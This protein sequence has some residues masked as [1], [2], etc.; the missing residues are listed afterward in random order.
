MKVIFHILFLTVAITTF[1]QNTSYYKK[2]IDTLCSKEMFGRGYLKNGHKIAAN[3]IQNELERY[4]FNVIQQNFPI[5]VNTFPKVSNIFINDSIKLEVG[6]DFIPSPVCG[7]I[8][9]EFEIFQIDS[10]FIYSHKEQQSFIHKDLS[11]TVLV[12]NQKITKQINS[13]SPEVKRT[14]G[15][16]AAIITLQDSPLLGSFHTEASHIGMIDILDTS[17]PPNAAKIKLTIRNEIKKTYSQNV[18]ASPN[19]LRKK[20]PT[21]LITGHY[22]HLGGYGDSCF[23]SGANDNAS[24]IAMML[25]MARHFKENLID[26]NLIFMACGGE[27]VGLIGSYY[28]TEHPTYPLKRLDL[29]INLDLMGAGSK[30]IM[31]ENGNELPDVYKSFDTENKEYKLVTEIKKRGN[32]PNSDHYPFTQKDVKAIFIYSLGEVGGYH[33]ILDSKDKLEYRSYERLFRLLVGT[34][35]HRLTK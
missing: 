25:D 2:Q 21:I 9:G 1:S 3:Y 18:I 34:I 30:G 6:K 26:A 27:E 13:L 11:R 10:S 4:D 19:K 7:S 5:T 29:V 23:V 32:S 17:F 14:F 35:E 31:I 16:S 15:L 20:I 28:Y 12:Y 24:G 8:S 22:D 33:N